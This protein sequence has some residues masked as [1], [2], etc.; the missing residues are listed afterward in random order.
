MNAVSIFPLA[1][2]TVYSAG[3]TSYAISL[4]AVRLLLCYTHYLAFLV[5]FFVKKITIIRK[6]IYVKDCFEF[7]KKSLVLRVNILATSH[8]ISGACLKNINYRNLTIY[9]KFMRMSCKVGIEGLPKKLYC[10]TNLYK[11]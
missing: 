1:L 11:K 5:K 8:S 4:L 2:S 7:I 9:A 10:Q 3:F 6:A